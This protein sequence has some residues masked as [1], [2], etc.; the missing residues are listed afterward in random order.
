M[1]NF[2]GQFR[3]IKRNK[4]IKKYHD[5]Q[6]MKQLTKVQNEIA[7]SETNPHYA[8]KYRG[9]EIKFWLNIP[10]WIYENKETSKY[11]GL[12][13]GC[14]YGT[15]ALFCKKTMDYEM[16]CIDFTDIYRDK[17]LFKKYNI[18][19][20]INNIEFDPF[21]WDVKFDFVIFTETLEHLNF[22]PIP[23]LKKIHSVLSKD[24]K[25]Y[26]TTPDATEWGRVTKVYN[27][28]NDMPPPKK[29]VP[30]PTQKFDLE[31]GHVYQYTKNELLHILDKSGFQVEK[32]DYSPAHNRHF[33]IT[34]KKKSD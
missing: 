34:L 22:N 21:P 28:I 31:D 26:L 19:F 20:A 6:W 5:E 7:S 2:K 24:G 12:D 10:K 8:K 15:L 1:L 33:N 18:S 16:Y 25:L 3:R 11:V 14:A 23:T 9:M 32:F 17:N 4:I 29:G 30:L 13:I 27:N